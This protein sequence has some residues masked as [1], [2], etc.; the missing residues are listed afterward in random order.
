MTVAL[1]LR[2]TKGSALTYSEMDTNLTNLKTAADLSTAEI[3]KLT[4]TVYNAPLT[5]A[6]VSPAAGTR[7]L[8]INPAGTILALTVALPPSPEDGQKIYFD[9]N[10]NNYRFDTDSCGNN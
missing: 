5:G 2:N 10:P 9:H 1:T 7:N 4:A 6:T 8:I 3:S